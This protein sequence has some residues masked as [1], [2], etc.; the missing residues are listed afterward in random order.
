MLDWGYVRV[1]PDG[2]GNW[3]LPVVSKELGKV[4]LRQLC[5]RLPH[6]GKWLAQLV[7][8]YRA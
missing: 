4:C 5:V 6:W 3:M 8:V 7:Q 1:S 2:E